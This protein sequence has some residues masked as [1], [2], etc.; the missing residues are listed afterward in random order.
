MILSANS[1]IATKYISKAD[2]VSCCSAKGF[3]LVKRFLVATGNKNQSIVQI[4][5]KIITNQL[6]TS[7]NFLYFDG[8]FKKY[9][10]IF[11]I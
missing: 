11:F 5:G 9:C 10:L 3:V 8:L 7:S 6:Q 4:I 1:A 2:K